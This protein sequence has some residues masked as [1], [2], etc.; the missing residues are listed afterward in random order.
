MRSYVFIC[1]GSAH[2]HSSDFYGGRHIL[3]TYLAKL[4]DGLNDSLTVMVVE[5]EKKKKNSVK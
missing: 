4:D 5:K 3:I 2:N 1:K